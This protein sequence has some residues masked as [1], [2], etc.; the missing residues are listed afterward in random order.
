MAVL[1]Q[2]LFTYDSILKKLAINSKTYYNFSILVPV[3]EEFINHANIDL[4]WN[5]LMDITILDTTKEEVADLGNVINDNL[6]A[7]FNFFSQ[8]ENYGSVPK[9]V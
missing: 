5:G 8:Q 4:K 7:K 6:G 1:C 3:N 2:S 9:F